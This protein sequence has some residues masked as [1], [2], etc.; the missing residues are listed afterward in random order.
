MLKQYM[1]VLCLPRA[2]RVL[3]LNQIEPR[4]LMMFPIL[5]FIV[6]ITLRQT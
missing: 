3:K 4:V 5:V 1:N 6:N 2:S